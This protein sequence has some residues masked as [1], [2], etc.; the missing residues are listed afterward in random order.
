M[1]SI[2]TR[3][4]NVAAALALLG[5]LSACGNKGPLVPPKT[6]ATLIS[7]FNNQ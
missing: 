3:A 5:A 2:L 1:K 6:S 7:S 4:L